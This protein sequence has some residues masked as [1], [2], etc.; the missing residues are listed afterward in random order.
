G[1]LDV[2]LLQPKDPLFHILVSR[3]EVSAWGDL[4]YGLVLL[5]FLTLDP[6][7][8]ALFLLFTVTGALVFVAFFSLVGSL[9][10]WWGNIE[11]LSGALTEFLLSFTLYPDTVF[12][13]E[14]RWVFY[15]VVPAGFLAFLPLRVLRDLD[16]VWLPVVVGA[17]AALLVAAWAAFAAGVR[18]YESGNAL[19]GR[20]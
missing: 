14:M 20:V 5:P 13:K 11:G 7:K 18:R 1:E 4:A 15:S 17:A 6:V 2:Y 16:W 10:F 8:M 9:A 19:G 3:T 12:P